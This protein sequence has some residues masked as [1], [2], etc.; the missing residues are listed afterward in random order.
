MD[1]GI[2]RGGEDVAVEAEEGDGPDLVLV[3]WQRLV[4]PALA[5]PQSVGQVDAVPLHVFV[6]HPAAS[7]VSADCAHPPA[8]DRKAG[9]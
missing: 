6:K 2:P 7:A 9:N 5:H 8:G 4:E 3:L 1:H